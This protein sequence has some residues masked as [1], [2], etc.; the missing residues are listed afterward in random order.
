MFYTHSLH[1]SPFAVSPPYI[2]TP[3]STS[4]SAP[5][6]DKR[7]DSRESYVSK[8]TDVSVPTDE[9]VLAMH[10]TP[11]TAAKVNFSRTT[12]S[13][14]RN[15]ILPRSVQGVSEHSYTQFD[16]VP[17]ATNRAVPVMSE[18]F[19]ALCGRPFATLRESWMGL[20]KSSRFGLTMAVY[21]ALALVAITEEV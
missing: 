4:H 9:V 19:W 17:G 15:Q 12:T 14:S 5:Q 16:E 13:D 20:L 7:A 1:R 3:R 11:V 18:S 6:T 10:D 8:N 2:Q 21:M